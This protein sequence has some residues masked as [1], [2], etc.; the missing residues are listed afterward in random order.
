MDILWPATVLGRPTILSLDCLIGVADAIAVDTVSASNTASSD[1]A[2]G[3]VLL[4]YE[5]M[6]P[7][8]C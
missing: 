4:L 8:S 3:G 1:A 6:A 7:G 5:S 2:A